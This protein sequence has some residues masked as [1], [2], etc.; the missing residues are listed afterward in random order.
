MQRKLVELTGDGSFSEVDPIEVERTARHLREY[1]MRPSVLQENPLGIVQEMRP[2]CEGCLRGVLELPLD[3]YGLPYQHPEVEALLPAE[4][5][6]VW[7]PF[8]IAAT[9]ISPRLS[10]P[11]V[12]DGERY[13]ER[14]FEEPGDWPDEV[15]RWEA[16]RRA[17]K[18]A[19]RASN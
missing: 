13:C 8:V 15:T 9:G 18:P 7:R 10:E 6:E 14:V 16:E 3:F 4:F 2:L 5:L 19:G 11:Q 12:I 17:M 1:L